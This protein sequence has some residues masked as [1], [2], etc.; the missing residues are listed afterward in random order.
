MDDEDKFDAFARERWP[1]FVR[2]A[3]FLGCDRSEAQDIA[4]LTL[5]KCWRGWHRLKSASSPDAY[6]FRIL[7]NCFR[8]ARRRL[9]SRELPDGGEQLD[10]PIADA[11]S[12]FA[13]ADVVHRAL[14]E[15]PAG[16]REVVVLRHLVGLSERE[17][18]SALRLPLGTVKSRAA[19]GI[20]H[21]AGNPHLAELNE[22]GIR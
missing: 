18:A 12:A 2:T 17:T 16:T 9:S 7:H 22:R 8:D 4:Q 5:V 13:S 11:T 6:A 1:D 20:A 10:K 21:L 19:R 3:I 14:A 15:L